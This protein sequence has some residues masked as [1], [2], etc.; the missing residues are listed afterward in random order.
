MIID[1][2]TL[3][4]DDGDTVTEDD[5]TITFDNRKFHVDQI[6][7]KHAHLMELID[8]GP[9]DTV[10]YWSIAQVSDELI[11]VNKNQVFN[12]PPLYRPLA[13]RLW[14]INIDGASPDFAIAGVDA[15]AGWV[16]LDGQ[17]DLTT[18]TTLA[19]TVLPDSTQWQTLTNA[20]VANNPE[21]S[22]EYYDSRGWRRL[23]AAFSDTTANLS[24]TGEIRFKVANDL[25]TTK[26]GGQEDYWIRARLIGGDYGQPSFLIDA[27]PVEPGGLLFDQKITIDR[28][29]VHPP[30]I[31]SIEASFKLKQQIAPELT[32]TGNNLGVV[33]QSAAATTRGAVFDLFAAAATLDREASEPALYLGLSKPFAADALRLLADAV[34]QEGDVKLVWQVFADGRWQ[35]VRVIDDD[36]THGLLRP[37]ID[38]ARRPGQADPPG[39]LRPSCLLAARPPTHRRRLAAE[40]QRHLSE[41]RPGRAGRDHPWR[42]AGLD[43]GRARRRVPLGPGRR[44]CGTGSSCGCGS[45]WTAR[46]GRRWS[47]PWARARSRATC[48]TFGA[49][50]CSGSR[51][52][53]WSTPMPGRASSCSIDAPARSASATAAK[54]AVRPPA[55]TMS[56]PF[57]TGSAAVRGATWRPIRSRA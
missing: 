13:S 38:H 28:S 47:T 3:R 20:D 51:S 40:A 55:R 44:S 11:Q 17:S 54:G 26:I 30:E 52:T 6:T 1:D 46:T 14:R 45:A 48:P 18:A 24:N 37:G 36:P 7:D 25:A 29:N 10:S 15:S 12:L 19:I 5:G 33:D 32:L 42:A 21:L 9:D 16:A 35:E 22:W 53:A 50:G 49:T 27:T 39:A 2:H 31:L 8:G 34:E 23:A 56:A 43:H 57:S 41:C 4:L